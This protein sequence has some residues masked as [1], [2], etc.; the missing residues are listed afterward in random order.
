METLIAAKV[1]KFGHICAT[2]T[3]GQKVKGQG[4]KVDGSGVGCT[5]W[6]VYVL[7]VLLL[8]VS[9]CWPS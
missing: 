3:V 8:K 6:C 7:L 4:L 5:S 9:C 1:T 2:V